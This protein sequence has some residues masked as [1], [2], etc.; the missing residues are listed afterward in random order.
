MIDDE[1][2]VVRGFGINATLDPMQVSYYKKSGRVS[3][4]W[5]ARIRDNESKMRSAFLLRP[6]DRVKESILDDWLMKQPSGD[7]KRVKDTLGIEGF[8]V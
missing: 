2:A 7:V 4:R 1:A 6:N 8:D 5:Q 3:V